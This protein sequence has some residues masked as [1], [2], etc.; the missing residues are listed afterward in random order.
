MGQMAVCCQNLTLGALSS[1]SMLSVLVGALFKKFG[2]FLDTPRIY[3]F[4]WFCIVFRSWVL[5]YRSDDSP[6]NGPKLTT[7]VINCVV[8]NGT[9]S[10]A[11][12]CI[13]CNTEITLKSVVFT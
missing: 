10:D 12:I 5:V 9:P 1:Y 11:F 4:V 6:K 2:L 3:K 13:L 7:F 8:H